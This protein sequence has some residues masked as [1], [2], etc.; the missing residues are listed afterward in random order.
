[1][2]RDMDLIR[3]L[4]LAIEASDGSV[5][6]DTDI[7]GTDTKIVGFHFRLLDDAGLI[8]RDNGES[9]VTQDTGGSSISWPE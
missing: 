1:M 5:M 3:R 4:L 7:E 6:S 2:K 8:Q 9:R